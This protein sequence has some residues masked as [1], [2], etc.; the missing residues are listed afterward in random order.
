MQE[1][2]VWERENVKERVRDMAWTSMIP[3]KIIEDVKQD[4]KS[5]I[6]VEKYKVSNKAIYLQGV[7]LPISAITSVR[8][9]P[10]T[11]SPNCCCGKGIPVFKIRIDYGAEK[12][13]VLMLEKEQ[14]AEKAVGIIISAN[15][16]VSIEEACGGV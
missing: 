5:A 6:S 14:N 4:R 3:D 1:R 12:P 2:P 9:Q 8:I 7:Y 15:N 16:S 10:S 13:L 11:Y